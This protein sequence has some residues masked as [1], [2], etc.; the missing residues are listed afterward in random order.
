M[1]C[2]SKFLNQPLAPFDCAALVFNVSRMT[3]WVPQVQIL[4]D[5]DEQLHEFI[6]RAV[7]DARS[8][9]DAP[10]RLNC[11]VASRI[12]TW[13]DRVVCADMPAEGPASK[14]ACQQMPHARPKFWSTL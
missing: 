11:P 10:P 2:D 6:T 14:Q 3:D 9:P 12:D 13:P 4:N 7:G 5:H 1:V 8:V